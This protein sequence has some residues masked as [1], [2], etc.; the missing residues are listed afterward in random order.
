MGRYINWRGRRRG[1]IPIV[2]ILYYRPEVERFDS[3]LSIDRLEYPCLENSEIIP[4]EKGK[5]V[6]YSWVIL[7]S[8]RGDFYTGNG[9]GDLAVKERI[10]YIFLTSPVSNC[11]AEISRRTILLLRM[12]SGHR[13]WLRTKQNT[14]DEKKKKR[15][16]QK[17]SPTNHPVPRKLWEHPDPEST[18][19]GKFRRKLENKTGLKFPVSFF[20]PAIAKAELNLTTQ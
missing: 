2:Y 1:G 4:T 12:I 9:N 16:N 7:F 19:L 17:M 11:G 3:F 20:Y 15:K 10:W 13:N 8:L 18:N 5:L 6:V 14:S